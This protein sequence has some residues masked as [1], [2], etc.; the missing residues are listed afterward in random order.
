MSNLNNIVM[1]E[2]VDT[3]EESKV[4]EF[5]LQLNE[6]AKGFL[7]EAAKWAYFLSILGYI[8]IGL[9]VLA[10][11]FAGTLFGFIG[12]MMPLEQMGMFSSAF[13]IF[14]TV[15][16]LLIAAL[17]F[18]PIYYLNRFASNLRAAFRDNDSETLAKSFEYLKSHYK[19]IGIL[20]VIMLCF[21]ALIFAGVIIAAITVGL[22]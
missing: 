17:Y 2:I 9:I 8:G 3:S 1:E 15:V 4:E 22:R 20:A 19:F 5:E 14:I 18:F 11:I 16:Y 6:S 21:Y 12:N 10:A 7:K 13:G